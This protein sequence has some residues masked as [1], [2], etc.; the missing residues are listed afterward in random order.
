MTRAQFASAIAELGGRVVARL[1]E[2]VTHV[3]IGAECQANAGSLPAAQIQ[4]AEQKVEAGEQICI[5]PELDFLKSSG[6][7]AQ[8]GDRNLHSLLE[9]TDILNV[10]RDCILHWI[11]AGL[12]EPVETVFGLHFFEFRE[13]ARLRTLKELRQNGASQRQVAFGL[14]RIA[15]WYPD[16]ADPL[17]SLTD[18]GSAEQLVFRLPDG[19]M[20]EPSGQQVFDFEADT[21]PDVLSTVSMVNRLTMERRIELAVRYEIAGQFEAA[22]AIYEEM[23]LDKHRS[24]ELVFNFGNLRY[25]QERFAEAADMYEAALDLD[26][27]YLEA[28]SNLGAAL[29]ELGDLDDAIDA[30]QRLLERNPGFADAH[31]NLAD[32]LEQTGRINEARRH[33]AIYLR[34][35]PRSEWAAHARKRLEESGLRAWHG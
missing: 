7:Y 11:A 20:L 21:E 5:L 6:F 1:S 30:Y 24:P 14:R 25:A 35:D 3:V 13:V 22:E 18:S 31:F 17:A 16:D 33:W 9:L 10:S 26:G 8:A 2:V 15:R 19:R 32:L 4:R 34:H 29:A 23:I 12:L 27:D 28:L